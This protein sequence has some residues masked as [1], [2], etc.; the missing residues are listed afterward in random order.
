MIQTFVAL[1]L[2]VMD[3][4]RPGWTDIRVGRDDDDDD[5]EVRPASTSVPPR[6]EAV[7]TAFMEELVWPDRRVISII[8]KNVFYNFFII[9]SFI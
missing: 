2:A 1:V 5:V 6:W 3:G 4:L 9:Y 7:V 8:V